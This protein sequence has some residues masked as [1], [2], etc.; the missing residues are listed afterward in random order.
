MRHLRQ[1]SDVS[2]TYKDKLLKLCRQIAE[3]LDLRDSHGNLRV[4]TILSVLSAED[5]LGCA[6]RRLA[7]IKNG[8]GNDVADS[9]YRENHRYVLRT[10][11]RRLCSLFRRNGFSVNVSVEEEMACSTPDLVVTIVP[12]GHNIEVKIN[13][14]LTFLIEV[15]TGEGLSYSQLVRQLADKPEATLILLR[16]KDQTCKA[17]VL[18]PQELTQFI[19]SELEN[20]TF[21]AEELLKILK[22]GKVPTCNHKQNNSRPQPPADLEGTLKE[23][24]RDTEEA[25]KQLEV[26][27]L[28]EL[29]HAFPFPFSGGGPNEGC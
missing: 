3:V 6:Y 8:N 23:L 4:K 29:R 25:V 7:S 13:G 17:R 20:L 1:V 22:A 15:K 11:C 21:K 18:H 27:V 12:N 24:A 10:V 14:E 5:C 16:I 9:I 2:E 19:E 26:R 28:E